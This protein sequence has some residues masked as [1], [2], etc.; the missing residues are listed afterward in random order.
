MITA[1]QH[2]RPTFSLLRGPGLLLIFCLLVGCEEEI[3]PFSSID[4]PFSI[5][6]VINP[7][8]DTQAVR[9]FPIDPTLDLVPS[10]TIDATTSVIDVDN[11]VR[12]VLVDSVT[13]LPSGDFRHTFWAQF[14]VVHGNRYRVEVERSDGLITRSDEVRVPEPISLSAPEPTDAQIS[15][16]LLPVIIDGNPPSLP[17]I[18]VTYNSFSANNLG[19][20]QQD[21]PITLNYANTPVIINDTLTLNIDMQEDFTTIRS[22]F[23]SR[24]LDGQICIDNITIDVHV[25]NEEW[26]SPTGVFDP[27]VL[28]EPGTLSNV[29]NGFGFFGAGFIESI[30]VIPPATMQVRAGFFDCVAVSGS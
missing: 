19:T 24:D 27:N 15:D 5:W 9:I 10:E 26:R 2:V 13:Q 12:H 20:R 8:A 23:N 6:G 18:D 25:G 4:F 30:T 29:E 11:D 21:N 28:V 14:E 1:S 16:I 22:I 3:A 7:Q 17:R